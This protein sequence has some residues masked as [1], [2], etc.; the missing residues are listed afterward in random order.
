MRRRAARIAVRRPELRVVARIAVD[1]ARGDPSRQ[2]SGMR[3]RA[4]ERQRL[5][6]TTSPVTAAATAE[7][8]QLP[9]PK[10]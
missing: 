4:A 6:E 9:L 1:P 2:P 7:A 3:P 10:A 8:W 5:H